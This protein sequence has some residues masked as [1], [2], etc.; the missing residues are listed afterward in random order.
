MII[1]VPAVCFSRH[2]GLTGLA[3]AFDPIKR[4]RAE[5]QGRRGSGYV[6]ADRYARQQRRT[7][8]AI[9]AASTST[10]CCRPNPAKVGVCAFVLSAVDGWVVGRRRL[11]RALF[12][13]RHV[14]TSPP[15]PSFVIIIIIVVNA[16]GEEGTRHIVRAR[17]YRSFRLLYTA[18]WEHDHRSRRRRAFTDLVFS[19]DLVF[20]ATAAIYKRWAWPT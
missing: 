6:G 2:G 17:A 16:R 18:R 14:G 11:A 8:Q 13:Q 9:A 19:P 20:L 7:M 15:P 1:V 5:R 4:M 3:R 10:V 12:I